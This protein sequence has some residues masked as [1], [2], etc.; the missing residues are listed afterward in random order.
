M[1]LKLFNSWYA[2]GWEHCRQDDGMLSC[3]FAKAA[4]NTPYMVYTYAASTCC[5]CLIFCS[6]LL[7]LFWASAAWPRTSAM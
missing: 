6:M 2:C 5:T 3:I 1:F 7:S 4:P